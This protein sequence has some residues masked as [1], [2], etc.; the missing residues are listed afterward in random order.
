M[1]NGR[2]YCLNY[3]KTSIDCII[4]MR[5]AVFK[6]NNCYKPREEK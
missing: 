3:D 6:I 5:D 4:C 2:R 1:T